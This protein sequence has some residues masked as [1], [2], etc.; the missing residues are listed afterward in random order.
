MPAPKDHGGEIARYLSPTGRLCS[1]CADGTT[2]AKTIFN[3][4]GQVW[5][6]KKPG[7]PLEQ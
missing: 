7:V 4:D 3:R 6:R 1:V 5:R 2:L